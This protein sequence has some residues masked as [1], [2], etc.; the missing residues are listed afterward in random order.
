MGD[1]KRASRE[2]DGERCPSFSERAS[3]REPKF[4]KSK[5]LSFSPPPPLFSLSLSPSLTFFFFFSFFVHPFFFSVSSPSTMGREEEDYP[6]AFFAVVVAESVERASR[7]YQPREE[8]EREERA[9]RSQES[10]ARS[11][12]DLFAVTRRSKSR[13]RS[14]RSFRG[15]SSHLLAL[16]FFATR[17]CVPSHQ[18]GKGTRILSPLVEGEPAKH[19]NKR[20][21][22]NRRERPS[23]SRV[24]L[25]PFLSLPS[26][27]K[28]APQYPLP[29]QTR[30]R[31]AS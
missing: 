5:F 27:L 28:N 23:E 30:S 13:Q 2:V 25:T 8:R 22:I 19:E 21:K 6:G 16:L 24:T 11:S 9:E 17:A 12:V 31:S 18:G 15:L 20:R 4:D 1:G 10:D 29:Q 26:S 3:E 14:D 7:A